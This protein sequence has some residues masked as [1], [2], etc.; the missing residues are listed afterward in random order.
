V[1]EL[2]PTVILRMGSHSEK[3]YI[4]KTLKHFDGLMVGANL[5]QI[6]PGATASL[7]LKLHKACKRP[8][9][10]D[11]MTYAFGSYFDP[12]T[13]K[14]RDDLDWIKSEQKVPG[15]KGV[16]ERKFKGSYR[17]L[18]SYFGEPFSTALDRGKALTQADFPNDQI[19]DEACRTVINFQAERLREVFKEDPQTA[20]YA[21]D[22]P[23]PGAVFA[24]YFYIEPNRAK[25]WLSLNN[26][27][28]LSTTQQSKDIPV[29]VVVCGHIDLLTNAE[30]SALVVNNL[31]ACK[32]AGVWLW[33]SRFD[34]RVANREQLL[35]L[36]WWVEKLTTN[37]SV[38]NMHGGFFSLA[39]SKFGM[40]GTMHGVG[41]GEQKDVVP[42]IGQ[43]TPTVQYY[44]RSLHSKYSVLQIQRCFTQ[45][46]IRTAEDFFPKICD[47]AICKH[48]VG[49][50]LNEFS[51][52][53]EI[54]YS[55]PKSKR[56]AQTPAAAKRCRFHFL[57]NRILE[58][59][60][61]EKSS[62]AEIADQC[63]TSAD[64][65]S[66]TVVGPGSAHAKVWADVLNSNL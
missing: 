57:L 5:L 2:R 38:F 37:M 42:V 22:L 4:E 26:R 8:Y 3:E 62:L 14:V 19:V 34:E 24:P 28:A 27:L 50:G 44:L 40:A 59:D 61:V 13:G 60:Y 35:A 63:R 1:S 11:P 16:T 51:Q 30:Y 56:A 45:L 41:Y 43:S 12:E 54:H 31:L 66:K 6:S 33:F 20:V 48:I 23:R 10:I 29:H 58:R 9:F 55:T 53:G 64:T 17:K 39:L 32:P 18:A 21:N 36:R 46:G 49:A 52:F 47:C 65:W 15:K 7:L 25:H